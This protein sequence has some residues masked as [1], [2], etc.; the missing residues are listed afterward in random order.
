MKAYD[1]EMCKKFFPKASYLILYKELTDNGSVLYTDKLKK[2]LM[3][4]GIYDISS[5]FFCEYPYIEEMLEYSTYHPKKNKYEIRQEMKLQIEDFDTFIQLYDSYYSGSIL[6]YGIFDAHPN[7]LSFTN[8]DFFLDNLWF[9][10]QRVKD[11]SIEEIPKKLM[12]YHN[13]KVKESGSSENFLQSSSGIT[14]ESEFNNVVAGRRILSEKDIYL[15]SLIAVFYIKGGKYTSVNKPIIFYDFH[16]NSSIFPIMHKWIRHNFAN[17]VLLQPVRNTISRLGSKLRTE[18]GYFSE[19]DLY[20]SWKKWLRYVPSWGTNQIKKEVEDIIIRFRFEDLKL[21]PKEL[22]TILCEKIG[23]PWSDT[24]LEPTSDGEK[25]VYHVRNSYTVSGF[26]LKPVY[27]QYTEFFSSFDRFRLDILFYERQ[28][29]YD[30]DTIDF[31]CYKFDDQWIQELFQYPFKFEERYLKYVTHGE[32]NETRKQIQ[33]ACLCQLN[34][35]KN[36]ED[37]KELFNFGNVLQLN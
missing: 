36:K 28:K 5:H 3:K 1:I 12:E 33:E 35:M 17:Y 9:Y 4:E 2:F 18:I 29:A 21:H 20:D 16:V 25:T 14:F 37:R 19:R 27:N 10:I 15:A 7:I 22:L 30:Y 31:C 24:L 34:L 11:F 23:I 8:N 6:L 32:W 26:D 13:D